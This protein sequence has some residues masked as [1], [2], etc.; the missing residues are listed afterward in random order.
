MA[1]YYRFKIP[2]SKIFKFAITCASLD[3]DTLLSWSDDELFEGTQ[4]KG[5]IVLGT[6]KIPEKMQLENI[7][8]EFGK[9]IHHVQNVNEENAL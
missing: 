6:S 7:T 9:Y 8:N 2:E 4:I 3:I 5:I 1:S